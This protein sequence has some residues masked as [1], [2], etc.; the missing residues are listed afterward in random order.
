MGRNTADHKYPFPVGAN[1]ARLETMENCPEQ[2][3]ETTRNFAGFAGA[4]A[5]IEYRLRV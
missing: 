5:G 3:L 4:G 2:I 1:K